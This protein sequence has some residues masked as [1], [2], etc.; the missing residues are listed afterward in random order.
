MRASAPDGSIGQWAKGVS[1]ALAGGGF[2]E[3]LHRTA[4]RRQGKQSRRYRDAA[5]PAGRCNGPTGYAAPAF[6][7]VGW[8]NE[9]SRVTAAAGGVLEQAMAGQRPCQNGRAGT[10]GSGGTCQGGTDF[11][12][13]LCRIDKLG[14]ECLGLIDEFRPCG[15][16]RPRGTV[17]RAGHGEPGLGDA[18]RDTSPTVDRHDG[19]AP[20]QQHEGGGR[21]PGEFARDDRCAA[22]LFARGGR[23]RLA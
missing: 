2:P 3:R 21:D 15:L 5:G 12:R 22:C 13:G 1:R 6:A 16:S 8:L 9:A 7:D 18:G 20:V 4:E 19:V 17:G 23:A 11:T 10:E 14:Q